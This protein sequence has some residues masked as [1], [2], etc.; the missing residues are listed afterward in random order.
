MKIDST[1]VGD[2]HISDGQVTSAI[3]ND[4]GLGESDGLY[5][6]EDWHNEEMQNWRYRFW[7]YWLTPGRWLTVLW[8]R[9][10]IA[11]RDKK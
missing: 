7:Y 5:S 11:I 8:I 1:K 3:M 2:W 9:L 4:D 6:A 10:K